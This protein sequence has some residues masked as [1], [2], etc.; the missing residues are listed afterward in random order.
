MTIALV[1]PVT[2][3]PSCCSKENVANPPTDRLIASNA[4]AVDQLHSATLR[5]LARDAEHCPR[6]DIRRRSRGG[7][8]D[9]DK[10]RQSPKEVARQYHAARL[11]DVEA[12]SR[13]SAA[14][15]NIEICRVRGGPH[16]EQF[17]RR[18]VTL[19][20]GDV[21]DPANFDAA[22][23]IAG[24]SLCC[25]HRVLLGREDADT[26]SWRRIDMNS[27]D[28]ALARSGPYQETDRYQSPGRDKAP[29]PNRPMC[30]RSNRSP[31]PF[32]R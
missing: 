9:R 17:A 20:F 19:G 8:A 5:R 16:H 24:S 1:S 31:L 32:C 18:S 13:E 26:R 12:E 27:D 6:H 29:C 7:P 30:R 11:P 2:G 22:E 23:S 4:T 25:G 10:A 3:T 15:E 21:V 14:Q 28:P